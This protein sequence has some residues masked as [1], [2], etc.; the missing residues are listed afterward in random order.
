[1][2]SPVIPDIV[3][4]IGIVTADL[5]HGGETGEKLHFSSY[6]IFQSEYAGPVTPQMPPNTI[7]TPSFGQGDSGPKTFGRHPVPA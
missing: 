5:H 1:M 6:S 4:P 3:R 7:W 2:R